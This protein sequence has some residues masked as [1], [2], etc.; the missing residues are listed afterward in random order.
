M[1]VPVSTIPVLSVAI[2]LR[3]RCMSGSGSGLGA[4]PL[5]LSKNCPV[6]ECSSH[7]PPGAG[8][9]SQPAPT[10][11]LIPAGRLPAPPAAGP[12]G[13]R[14]GLRR[15]RGPRSGR[16][17]VGRQLADAADG[18]V[19][20]L[21][22][23]GEPEGLRRL[24]E[25]DLL[26]LDEVGGDHS[27]APLRRA[28]TGAGVRGLPPRSS[29]AP[30][31]ARE[32]GGS[33]GGA[34]SPRQSQCLTLGRLAYA[35][36]GLPPLALLPVVVALVTTVTKAHGGVAV[37]M[38]KHDSLALAGEFRLMVPEGLTPA[39]AVMNAPVSSRYGAHPL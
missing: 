20:P 11:R 19:G 24:V 30:A 32:A 7:S 35:Q 4:T 21:P 34:A 5:F 26:R 6:M 36:V 9:R 13:G 25:G 10:A 29:V 17:E 18:L 22:G 16:A 39:H 33:K 8:G 1:L 12:G 3:E 37:V 38:L 14:W 28:R 2:V 27:G 23:V 15:R 31:A